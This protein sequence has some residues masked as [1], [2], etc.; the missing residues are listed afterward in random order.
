MTEGAPT[1]KQLF[2]VV[3]TPDIHKIVVL[4]ILFSLCIIQ[5]SCV[6]AWKACFYL[7]LH[8]WKLIRFQNRVF[9]WQSAT[10]SDW[11]NKTKLF[12]F[13]VSSVFHPKHLTP[14]VA[15]VK[16]QPVTGSARSTDG[17]YIVSMWSH[18]TLQPFINRPCLC[19]APEA[20][21]SSVTHKAWLHLDCNNVFSSS[22]EIFS[23]LLCSQAL[24]NLGVSPLH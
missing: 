14:T 5:I 8:W 1:T 7:S 10:C 11:R 3:Y 19:R 4:L 16:L 17:V 20:Q 12:E 23:Y 15:S 9:Q 13:C 21:K 6:K 22:A 18:A 2:S 24:W